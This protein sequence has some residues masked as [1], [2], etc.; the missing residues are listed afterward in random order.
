MTENTVV[1]FHL[2]STQAKWTDRVYFQFLPLLC[3]N[4]RNT[5]LDA[6]VVVLS[7]GG[8]DCWCCVHK[9]NQLEC[10]SE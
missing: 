2:S 3:D 5:V 4:H 9:M 8:M 10:S 6:Q 7:G 1:I